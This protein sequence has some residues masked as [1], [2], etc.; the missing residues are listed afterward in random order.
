MKVQHTAD[1]F[2]K[3]CSK[4]K[5]P[6]CGN[7]FKIEEAKTLVCERGHSFDFS[8]K[9]YVNLLGKPGPKAYGAKLF[10]ARREIFN[11]GFYEQVASQVAS[12]LPSTGTVVDAGCGEGYYAGFLSSV[13]HD[14]DVIGIDISKDAINLACSHAKSPYFIV[15]DLNNIPM[16]DSTADAI[17]NILTPASYRSFFRILHKGGFI[18]KVIPNAGYLQEIRT[19]LNLPTYADAGVAALAG[20]NATITETRRITYQVPVNE[21][22]ACLFMDMTPLSLH[23]DTTQAD[24]AAI[25]RVTIDLELLILRPR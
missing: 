23:V 21:K 25:Q 18:V 7:E 8:K 5:C 16:M 24:L 12:V 14:A 1:K 2:A 20:Q 19:A 4:L 11:R 13:L 9:G 15:G 3:I 10:H 17:V 6:V 22:D